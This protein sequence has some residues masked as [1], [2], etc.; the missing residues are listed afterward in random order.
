M[1]C[2]T[3]LNEIALLTIPFEGKVFV[4]SIIYFKWIT[5]ILLC[6][7]ILLHDYSF[8]K[9]NLLQHG[10]Q[11]FAS[12]NTLFKPLPKWPAV[13]QAIPR[14]VSYNKRSNIKKCL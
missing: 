4:N 2:I 13:F 3:K 6:D 11:T 12:V 14:I 10:V 8:G 7:S 1:Y 5:F 9:Y